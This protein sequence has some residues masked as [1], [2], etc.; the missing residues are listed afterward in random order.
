MTPRQINHLIAALRFWSAVE[1]SSR[2]KPM[3]HPAVRDLFSP[4]EPPL[5]EVES[6]YLELLIRR[7]PEALKPM[8]TVQELHRETGI[9]LPHIK[10]K[11]E[12]IALYPRHLIGDRLVCA[13]TKKRSDQARSGR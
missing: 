13:A 5:S 8:A 11:L 4:A 10:M 6:M 2:V 1:K 12:S 9:S 7:P 3:E